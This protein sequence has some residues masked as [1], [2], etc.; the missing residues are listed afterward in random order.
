VT[1]SNPVPSKAE[2][3]I[4]PEDAALLV[5]SESAS[6]KVV[7]DPDDVFDGKTVDGYGF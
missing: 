2:I 1:E 3:P 5:Y 6:L 4:A 7:L